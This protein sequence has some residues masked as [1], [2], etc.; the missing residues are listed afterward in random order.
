[1]LKM[2]CCRQ[3]PALQTA[4]ALQ[5]HPPGQTSFHYYRI[6]SLIQQINLVLLAQ[7]SCL[8]Q[9]CF[10]PSE[11]KGSRGSH[12]PDGKDRT[13]S[14]EQQSPLKKEHLAESKYCQYNTAS[15][16]RGNGLLQCYQQLQQEKRPTLFSVCRFS[17]LSGVLKIATGHAET[18]GKAS[19][20][21]LQWR[22]PCSHPQQPF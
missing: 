20:R 7:F 15:L 13:S 5:L 1:M 9:N 4:L 8:L 12:S 6:H 11:R 17:V 2:R 3:I 14:L 18:Q 19:L 10:S 22:A 21:Q 16:S